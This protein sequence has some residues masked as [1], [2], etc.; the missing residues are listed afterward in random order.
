MSFVRPELRAALWRW[1]EALAAGAVAALGL[2]LFLRGLRFGDWLLEGLGAVLGLGAL[3][4]LWAAVQ[5]ARFRSGGE[6]PGVVRV[7]ERRIAYM[8]PFDGGA[9]SVQS[10]SRLEIAAASDGARHW[11][12]HHPDG[13]PLAIPLDAAGAEALFDAFAALPGLDPARL[14][15]AVARGGGGAV[16]TRPAR[17]SRA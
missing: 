11:L 9:V 7:T 13:P 3:A 17:I 6:G 12:L 5:R 2:W 15:G 4:A 14:A 16:W 8:G 1:R 10:L